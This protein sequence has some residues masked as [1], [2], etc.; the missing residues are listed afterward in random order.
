VDKIILKKITRISLESGAQE[1]PALGTRELCGWVK[2]KF[3]I[4]GTI[5]THNI[6]YLGKLIPSIMNLNIHILT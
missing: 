5:K 3:K 1:S 2:K 4:H 6:N